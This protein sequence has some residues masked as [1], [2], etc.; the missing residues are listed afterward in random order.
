MDDSLRKM[1][2]GGHALQRQ[3]A[4]GGRGYEDRHDQPQ[5]SQSYVGCFFCPPVSIY[6]ALL[7]LN[8]FIYVKFTPST[9]E[10]SF[11]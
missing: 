7:M 4:G 9:R 3:R 8:N 10:M 6:L 11:K 1:T 2:G 5:R